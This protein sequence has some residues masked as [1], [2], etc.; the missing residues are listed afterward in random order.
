MRILGGGTLINL[1]IDLIIC[2]LFIASFGGAFWVG[3]IAGKKKRKPTE[4]T[5][6]EVARAKRLKHDMQILDEYDGF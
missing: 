6:A 2:I 5:E 1:L 3:Y 4:Q